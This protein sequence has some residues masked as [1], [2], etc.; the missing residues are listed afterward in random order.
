M[1]DV[2]FVILNTMASIIVIIFSV[3]SFH[4][5]IGI[6]RELKGLKTMDLMWQYFIIVTT[7]FISLGVTRA[8]VSIDSGIFDGFHPFLNAMLSV[9]LILFFM[10]AV[11][12]SISLEEI[13]E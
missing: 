13:T 11:L 10:F 9:I 8:L 2:I 7:L 1:N 12:L 6:S 4:L 5:L 3:L